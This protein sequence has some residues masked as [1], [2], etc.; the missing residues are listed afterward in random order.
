MPGRLVVCATPIG[1]LDDVSARLVST[2]AGADAIFAEDTR[3]TRTLL[4]ALGITP[5]PL[6][7]FFA[8]NENRRLGEI[9]SRLEVGETVALVT[10]AGTPA[11][12]DP[13]LSAVRVADEVGAK[14]TVVPGPSAVT[15]AIA[16]S[17]LPSE[18]FVFDGFL[19][20]SGAG[21]R[22]RLQVLAT[23]ER[24]VVLFSA[25]RRVL[26]DLTDLEA[27]L[28]GDRVVVIGRELTKVHEERWRGTLSE[29]R[30]LWSEVTPRGEFTLVIAP[31][32]RARPVDLAAALAQVAALRGDGL[33][34]PA[35]VKRAALDHE[36]DR[37][38]LYG[39]VITAGSDPAT[40]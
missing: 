20:R 37:R 31:L 15:A 32:V 35:A 26:E 4:G 24:T 25:T 16:L 13:G 28:G 10:D 5:P 17:G 21:R 9:R 6:R 23:E 2:L 38:S 36:V 30:H 19:P 11:V 7:S 1:N 33:S 29:A 14:V 22:R 39:A 40:K 18:R 27:A 8:G 12:A 34:L 3:R